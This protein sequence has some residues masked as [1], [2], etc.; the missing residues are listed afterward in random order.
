MLKKI[1]IA[2]ISLLLVIVLAAARGHRLAQGE[3]HP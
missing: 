2:L 1:G 3:Q